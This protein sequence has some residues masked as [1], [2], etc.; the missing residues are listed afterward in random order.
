MS[1]SV[2]LGLHDVWSHVC[3]QVSMKP[4]CAVP[5]IQWEC[6]GYLVLSS[7]AFPLLLISPGNREDS[8]AGTQPS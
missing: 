2:Q 8:C 3:L 5:T 4:G 1:G 7:H 6:S